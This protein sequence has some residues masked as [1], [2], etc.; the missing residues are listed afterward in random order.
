MSVEYFIRFQGKCYDVG[1]RLKFRSCTASYASIYEGTIE[2]ITHNHVGIRLVDGREYELSKIRGLDKLILEIILPVY[3]KEPIVEYAC[4]RHYPSEEN[5]FVGWVWYIAIML[6]GLIFKDRL[7]IWVFATT[8]F[9]LWKSGK[10]G[11]NK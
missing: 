7:L 11:G 3:Y 6:I 10:L 2:W 5:M 4:D 9:F 8:V 1:T